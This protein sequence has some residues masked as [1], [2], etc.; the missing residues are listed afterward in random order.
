MKV[1]H[2]KIKDKN[3]NKVFAQRNKRLKTQDEGIA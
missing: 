2:K 3:Q 1:L